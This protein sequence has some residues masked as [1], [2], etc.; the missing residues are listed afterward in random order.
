VGQALPGTGREAFTG[1]DGAEL[2]VGSIEGLL[3]DGLDPE[4]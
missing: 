1:G 3:Y 4:K 2:A